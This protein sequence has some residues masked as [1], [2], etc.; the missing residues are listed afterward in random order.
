MSNETGDLGESIFNLVIS[1]DKIFRP[2]HLGEKW[3][4]SDFYVELIGLKKH[5]FFIVQVKSTSRGYDAQGNLRIQASK[6]KL[7][8]L[9][10]YYCPTYLAGV[11]TDT[12]DV[13]MTAINKNKRKSIS[14]MPVKFKL[15][16]NSRKELFDEIIEFWENSKLDTY[17]RQ[18]KHK[19]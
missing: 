12:E 1:R 16:Q 9:N 18:F 10:S 14:K 6:K 13:F 15:D 8:K 7:H 2:R 4:T 3:P 11:D 5:Y 17:K 19:L